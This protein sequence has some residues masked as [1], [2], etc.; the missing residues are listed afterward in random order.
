[1]TAELEDFFSNWQFSEYYAFM[2]SIYSYVFDDA[3][4]VPIVENNLR[5]A[6]CEIRKSWY[7]EFSCHK[8]PGLYPIST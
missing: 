5:F 7:P 8:N 1:M 6:I 4:F 3:T 2:V